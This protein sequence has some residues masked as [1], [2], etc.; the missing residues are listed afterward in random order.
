MALG[1]RALTRAVVSDSLP[2]A[3]LPSRTRGMRLFPDRGWL[4][5]LGG[6]GAGLWDVSTARLLRTFR[7][8]GVE[9][10]PPGALLNKLDHCWSGWGG[11]GN[12]A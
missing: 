3:P 12:F 9:G 11:G 5:T 2:S 4:L 6:G 10:A 8:D 7:R 1:A